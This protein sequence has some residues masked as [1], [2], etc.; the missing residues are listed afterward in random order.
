MNLS[1][2]TPKTIS[3][4]LL[5]SAHRRPNHPALISPG[6]SWSYAALLEQASLRARAINALGLSSGDV[7]G[8]AMDDGFEFL[9]MMLGASMCGVSMTLFAPDVRASVFAPRLPFLSAKAFIASGE[10]G[11]RFIPM[12][13]EAYDLIGLPPAP[14]IHIDD[15]EYTNFLAAGAASDWDAEA[16]ARAV[17]LDQDA[18]IVFTSG[19]TG[20]PKTCPFSHR[21][22]MCKSMPFARRFEMDASSRLWIGVGMFQIGFIAPFFA[23]IELGATLLDTSGRD[24]D[25]A[26]R[27]LSAERVTHAYPIYLSSWLPIVNAPAFR[28]S[29]F[30]DLTHICLVGPATALRRVQRALPHAAVMSTYGSA[31]T[32][33]AFCMPRAG[34]AAETRLSSSGRPFPAHEI[35]IVDPEIGALLPAGAVGEIQVRGEG[36]PEARAANAYGSV[37]TSDGWLRMSDLGTLEHDGRLVYRGRLSEMLKIGGEMVPAIDIETALTSHRE[38]AVAQVI[39][40]PDAELGEV[41]AAFVELRP[42]AAISASDLVAFCRDHLPESHAPRFIRFVTDWP[43]TSS[44]IYKPSLHDMDVGPRIES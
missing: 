5:D 1:A 43:T 23:A 41:A 3:A 14:A 2:A 29:E 4:A 6:A 21:N 31:D 37:W 12:L 11:R 24:H 39:G 8:L 42:G 17:K 18:G 36:V 34:D 22:I 28:P 10:E 30:S 19:M 9:A 44:K 33:G 20:L 35:R 7:L 16:A 40:R 27:F 13:A 25:S 32:A 26:R 15:P 38:V